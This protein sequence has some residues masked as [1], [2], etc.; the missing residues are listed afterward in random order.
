MLFRSE[1]MEVFI[2][3]G[4]SRLPVYEE[5]LDNI[6]GVLYVKDTLKNLVDSELGQTVGTLMRKPL[7]IMWTSLRMA[8]S[9]NERMERSATRALRMAD[10]EGRPSRLMNPPGI[11]PAE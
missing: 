1:A 2:E 5:S 9:N 7:F 6:V 10:S 11:F 4:Y 3:H 8:S